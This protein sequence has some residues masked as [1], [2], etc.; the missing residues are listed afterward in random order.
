MGILTF[1]TDSDVNGIKCPDTV[2]KRRIL[3]TKDCFTFKLV[4][5]V[6]SKKSISL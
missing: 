1:T 4:M 3:G 5:L 2:W 6:I